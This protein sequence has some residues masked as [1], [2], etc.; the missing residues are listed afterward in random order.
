MNHTSVLGEQEKDKCDCE[1]K[2]AKTFLDTLCSIKKGRIAT[3][4]YKKP[5]D[6]NQYLLPSSCHPKQTTLAIPSS[7]AIRIAIIYLDPNTKDQRLH[8][9]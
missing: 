3:D 6:R 9:L 5:T 8:E 4:C 2:S 1:P 7:L